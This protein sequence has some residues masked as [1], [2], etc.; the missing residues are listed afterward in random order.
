[1]NAA[2]V[3][4]TNKFVLIIIS[5]LTIFVFL[6]CGSKIKTLFSKIPSDYSNIHFNNTIVEN[7]SIN[8]LDLEFLYNGGGIGVGD[9]NN[10]GL[11]DLYFTASTV[12]NKL[13]L[14]KGEMKFEDIT[15]IAN[16]QGEGEWFNAASVVD[17]NNDGWQDLYLCSSIKSNAANRRNLLYVNQGLNEKKQPV[18]K[19][20]AA[21]YGLADTSFSVHAAFFDYDNDGDLDMYLVTTKLAKREVASF[22]TNRFDT[23]HIDYDKFFRNDW[24]DSLKHSV[25]TNVSKEAGIQHPGYG[26]GVAVVDINKDG[27]KDVYVTNDFYGSDLM[28]I[29]NKNGTFTEKAKE[30][31]KHTSQNAMG[32]DV[33][34]I[35]NDGLAD[36]F[37]V[38]MNPES[39]YRKKTNMNGN[40][41]NIY[42]NMLTEKLVLQYV[43][44]T[45]QLNMGP[46]IGNND[47]IGEPIF[48]DIS[49]YAGVAETD[50]SWTASLADFDND[51]YRDLIVTNGYPK[52]VT[53]HDF[54]TFQVR[55]LKIA[56]KEMLMKEIPQIKVPNYAYRNTGQLSFEDVTKKWGMNE[57]SFSNGGIYADLDND[58]DLDY[59]INNINDEATLY[60]NT[61]NKKEK[62]NANYLQV[63]FKGDAKNING[64]GAMTEIYYDTSNLQV[65]ENFP[66]RGYLST[67]DCKA[68]FGLGKTTNIDSVVIRWP[69]HKKQVL[70]KVAANQVL[71]VDIANAKIDDNWS[72]PAVAQGTWFTDITKNAGISFEHQEMDFIDFNA[73]RLLPHKL[74]QYGPGLATG[75]IDKNGLD[76]I[77]LG[78]NADFTGK[79]FLQQADGKFIT[80]DLPFSRSKDARQPENQGLLLFDADSDGDLDLYC[81][82]GSNQFTPNT[83][84]YQD[85]FYKNDGKGNFVPDSLALP[86]NLISK[87]CVK[88]FDFDNDGDL[89][90]F[91]GG[92]VSPG[93]YPEAVSS[94]I[95]RN[96]SK[97]GVVKFTDISN[98]VASP[99]K[100]IGL[101]CDV[102]CSDFDNDGWTDLILAGEWMPLTFLRN[103]EGK[104]QDISAESG[105]K[106]AIGWW[107]SIAGGDF[108]NDGDMDYVVGNL[109]A[110]SFYRGSDEYPVNIYAKD[111]DKNKSFDAIPTV[112][113]KDQVGNRKEYT[114]QN[115]DDIVEQ[116][117][118]L[119]KR[120][121]TYKSFADA[122]FSKIFNP[123]ERNEALVLHANYFKSCLLK[124]NG[125]NK[126]E[127]IPLPM[128]AQIAPLY[129]M[130]TGDFNYDGN[131]DVAA[132]GN[133]YGTEV[134]N[135]RYDALNGLILLGDGTGNFKAAT[136]LQS[137]LFV[138]GDAKALVKLRGPGNSYLLAASQNRGPLKLFSHKTVKEKM[139]LLTSNDQYVL[140]TLANGKTRK[141]EI[142]YGNSFLSQSANFTCVPNDVKKVEIVNS[143]GEKRTLQ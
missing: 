81:A 21:E 51:G 44:N 27:W 116:L 23:A 119:K 86:A 42:R 56:T 39:N 64:L 121:L 9:F 90:L 1:M 58:G 110:N 20:M 93:R 52:D 40:N 117:P 85:Q 84:N 45:L 65:Y 141:E 31:F 61:L 98:E 135:G 12:S 24:N 72:V 129:G 11:P 34:D 2:V 22:S 100:N 10:D 92:R 83:L 48:G 43:R 106:S 14:N 118:I 125:N 74:S 134:S 78:A 75:D 71:K 54:I 60:E 8:P 132:C 126:F 131:L 123:E 29:N 107:G 101:V 63:Q 122:E 137:G 88:A 111:F 104:F 62:I 57:P 5:G 142:Y 89:D 113:L 99:L 68:H 140:I 130:V 47:S 94:F 46:R 6:S 103:N 136:I 69:N 36:I 13:Y 49:F 128:M 80:K 73:E 37:A 138:P 30:Y 18:F 102:I 28:Y 114:A 4:F 59:V 32:N 97:N 82:N 55:S 67:V 66:Y 127:L 53:D 115:R 105:V 50:W 120:F 87:S 91:L 33:A 26:L 109:G 17:I 3:N 95:Y 76:D 15:D 7:D 35:N 41:Y 25:F 38:D 108:D 19:E 96:D 16:V 79:F 77:Y 70:T 112:F 133:D 139:V 124:N 143:K